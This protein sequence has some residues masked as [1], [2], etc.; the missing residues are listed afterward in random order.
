MKFVV[1]LFGRQQKYFAVFSLF[2]TCVIR[3]YGYLPFKDFNE[4]EMIT[5][6]P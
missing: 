5:F 3:G 6:L 1:L 4:F 2:L